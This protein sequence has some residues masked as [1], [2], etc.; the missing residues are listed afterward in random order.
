MI[1]TQLLEE[2]QQL[3]K[4]RINY[5]YKIYLINKL[6]NYINQKEK[7]N[8]E[9]ENNNNHEDSYDFLCNKIKT[10]YKKI[11]D[12]AKNVYKNPKIF[13]EMSIDNIQENDQLFN[14]L[15]VDFNRCYDYPEEFERYIIYQNNSNDSEGIKCSNS[16]TTE[17]MQISRNNKDIPED[18]L[19]ETELN[20]KE[21]D[22]KYL[23]FSYKNTQSENTLNGFIFIFAMYYKEKQEIFNPESEIYGCSFALNP[24][25]SHKNEIRDIGISAI[26]SSGNEKCKTIIFKSFFIDNL[27]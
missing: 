19:I 18:D 16:H 21:E 15:I 25:Q 20:I 3:S 24:L 12:L 23:T 13:E 10:K 26:N 2:S 9:M 1:K 4:K 14:N 27:F 5:K 7:M 11:F 17:I 8:T 22:C 6:L